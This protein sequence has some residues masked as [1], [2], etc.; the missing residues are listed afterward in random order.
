MP[1]SA[2]PADSSTSRDR[3]GGTLPAALRVIFTA[4]ALFAASLAEVSQQHPQQHTEHAYAPRTLDE[5]RDVLKAELHYIPISKLYAPRLRSY[6]ESA[7]EEAASPSIPVEQQPEPDR[8]GWARERIWQ[9]SHNRGLQTYATTY[10]MSAKETEHMSDADKDCNDYANP[11]CEL[12]SVRRRMPM[13]L[14]A[15]W[16]Q[17][18]TKKTTADA[19][20]VAACKL[21]TEHF[22]IIDGPH[23]YL[24]HGTLEEFGATFPERKN[25][26]VPMS[27]MGITEYRLPKRD[28]PLNKL[29][30]QALHMC[31]EDTMK[32]L[33]V[34]DGSFARADL[35]Q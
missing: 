14:V 1:L 24:W 33:S 5:L 31:S 27:V 21:D 13:H 23:A 10:C 12:L 4:Q 19:H 34:Y 18:P 9:L 2:A 8:I 15:Y 17:H 22:V 29:M 6:T 25:D 35:P 16:P 20:V 11:A 3:R 32:T 26:L 30:L 28:I 7:H